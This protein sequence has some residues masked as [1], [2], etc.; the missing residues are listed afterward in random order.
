VAAD[1][2]YRHAIAFPG[3]SPSTNPK[4]ASPLLDAISKGQCY[5]YAASSSVGFRSRASGSISDLP[6][7]RFGADPVIERRLW[8]Y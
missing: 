4:S 2:T 6:A 7:W 5:S 1:L 3:R 8:R